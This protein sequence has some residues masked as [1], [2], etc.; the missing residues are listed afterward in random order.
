MQGVKVGTS[1][2]TRTH[3]VSKPALSSPY[4]FKKENKKKLT[5]GATT[6]NTAASLGAYRGG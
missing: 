6:A 1:L 4:F 2:L 3:T 5:T